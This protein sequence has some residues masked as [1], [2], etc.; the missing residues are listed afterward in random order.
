MSEDSD[1]I[2]RSTVLELI[3]GLIKHQDEN[4]HKWLTIHLAIQTT[5]I[6][7]LAAIFSW[8]GKVTASLPVIIRCFG[9]FAILVAI[10]ICL[11]LYRNRAYL[12][13]Y[14]KKGKEIQEGKYYI[15]EK[16]KVIKGPSLKWILVIIHVLIIGFWGFILKTHWFYQ[17]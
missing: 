9:V 5:L 17:S 15:W 12:G 6:T 1:K 16:Q 8:P 4:L 11:I 7:A 10:L 3:V 2:S 13:H 14:V